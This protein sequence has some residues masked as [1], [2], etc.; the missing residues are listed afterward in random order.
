MTDKI[1][2]KIEDE[3]I[4]SAPGIIDISN[5]Y[6]TTILH[7]LWPSIETMPLLT[8]IFLKY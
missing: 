8:I 3:L 5:D 2:N 6:F 4:E 7:K 1:V